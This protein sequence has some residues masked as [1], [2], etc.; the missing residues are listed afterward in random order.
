MKTTVSLH[1]FHRA[2]EDI[3]PDNFSY[4][5]LTALFEYF[6]EYEE[7]TEQEV[8][9]DVIA[10]CCDFTEYES[11]EEY[12]D[13]YNTT[14]DEFEAIENQTTCIVVVDV[15]EGRFIIQDY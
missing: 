9:L 14:V 13:N 3:R 2:F 8:E 6:E 4:A 11:F 5:G 7:G 1:D 12:N 15:D 10:I